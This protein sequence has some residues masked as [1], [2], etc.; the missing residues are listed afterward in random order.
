MAKALECPACGA[1]HRLDSLEPASTFRCD[2]CGQKLKVPA[3]V[4]A[5]PSGS[6]ARSPAAVAPPPR[7]RPSGSAA[8]TEVIGVSATLAHATDDR[9]AKSAGDDGA[10]AE[11]PRKGATTAPRQRVRWYWRL[12]AWLVAVPLGFVLTAWPAYEFGLIRKDDV[13]DVFVGS[14]TERYTRLAIVTLIWALV[15]AVLVQ[16]FI[17]GGRWWAARRRQRRAAGPVRGASA[18]G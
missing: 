14:G 15:T 18:T 8:T 7:R 4:A 2:R 12:L 5:A 13:L 1:K 9:D 6:E 16:V 3:S 11:A 10:P 17:E